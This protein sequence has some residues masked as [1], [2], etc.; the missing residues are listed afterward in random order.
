MLTLKVAPTGKR[1]MVVGQRSAVRKSGPADEYTVAPGIAPANR[2]ESLDEAELA[3]LIWGQWWQNR[4][5]AEGLLDRW[6]ARF[7]RGGQ[8]SAARRRR[9]NT[10]TGQGAT[11]SAGTKGESRWL[12]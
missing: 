7:G 3:G 12:E 6:H 2:L 11:C 5:R 10:A 1:A 9:A 8:M 4:E